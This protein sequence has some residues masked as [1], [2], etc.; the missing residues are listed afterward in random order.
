L[1]GFPPVKLIIAD[2]PVFCGKPQ[3]MRHEVPQK[4]ANR[5]FM[6]QTGGEIPA[7]F[8]RRS[9]NACNNFAF[10]VLLKVTRLFET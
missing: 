8:Y 5:T 7:A 10:L 2:S 1:A 4:K 6:P 9:Q 3:K